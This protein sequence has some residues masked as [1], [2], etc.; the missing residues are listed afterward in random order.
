MKIAAFILALATV[1]RAAVGGPGD[2][3]LRFLEKVQAGTV[4]LNPG[5]DTALAP[6]TGDRK[7]EE[8]ARRLARLALDLADGRFELGPVREQDGVAGVLVRRVGGYDPARLQ[9][10]AVALLKRGDAWLAAPLPA[11]F[12]N[13]GLGYGSAVRGSVAALEDWM[14]REQAED[15]AKLRDRSALRLRES[16]RKALPPE[17]LAGL[18]PVQM[19]ERFLE[20]CRRRDVPAMLG[21]LGGVAGETPEGWDELVRTLDS[22]G[23]AGAKVAR[24]WRLLLAG[25]VLRFVVDDPAAT[26]G[27]SLAIACVDPLPGEGRRQRVEVIP[28]GFTR[29]E[30][31]GRI[32]LP[33]GFHRAEPGAADGVQELSGSR[34]AGHLFASIARHAAPASG[35]SGDLRGAADA[36][37]AA[38]RAADPVAI[39]GAI[40]P[41]TSG[42]EADEALL[43]A[44]DLWWALHD[45]AAPRIALPLEVHEQGEDAMASFQFLGLRSTER[46]DLR[47][48]Q[49]RKVEG[50]WRWTAPAAQGEV[51]AAWAQEQ[52]VKWA[53]TWREHLL[54][55]SPKVADLATPA[56]DE[57]ACRALATA[58]LPALGRGDVKEAIARCARLATEGSDAWV[59]RNLGYAVASIRKD[60][61]AAAVTQVHAGRLVSAVGIRSPEEGKEVVRYYPVIATP[62]G[63]RLLVEVELTAAAGRRSRAFL[64]KTALERF[65]E[66]QPE[67]SREFGEWFDRI[68]RPAAG[69]NG[70]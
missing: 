56:P 50:V 11:S 64:N 29:H 18:T 16:I 62:S 32:T 21:L 38:L 3:A 66:A 12:E 47:C 1:A 61:S 27:Q 59:I 40:A 9:V 19:A 31:L 43:H 57:D 58:W 13:T 4:N 52:S 49:F 45:P 25:E 7:R 26:A 36:A 30:G 10:V 5:G 67:A 69:E 15:L 20:A 39:L 35:A 2:S 37:L 33:E 55:A 8:I 14:L 24:P 46:F 54:A 65:A 53:A 22:A 48:L 17:P 34:M 6:Q 51:A 68:D 70:P 44:M 28:L 63:P 23:A 42:A 41:G 60:A